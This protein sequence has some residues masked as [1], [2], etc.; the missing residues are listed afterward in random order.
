MI[1]PV[2]VVTDLNVEVDLECSLSLEGSIDVEVGATASSDVS[3]GL[4]Y[5]DGKMSPVASQ[6]FH[7]STVRPNFAAAAGLSVGCSLKPSLQLRF[8]GVMGRYLY[9]DFY[10][11]LGADLQS[12]C[13]GSASVPDCSASVSS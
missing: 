12:E 6:S 7:A 11:R 1:G 5:Q 10:D 2:P 9:A 3:A 8:Y 4:R 13:N